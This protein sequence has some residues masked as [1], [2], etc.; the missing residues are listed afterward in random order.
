[1]SDEQPAQQFA[2]ESTY[3]PGA[4]IVVRDEEWLVKNVTRTAHDGDRIEAVGISEFVRDQEAVFFTALDDVELMDP[5]KT[6]LIDDDSP[7]FRR[8]RFFLEAVLR[9]TPLPQ[10]ERGLALADSFLLDALPYQQ[11]PAQLALSGKNL[12][13]RMLIADVVG[14]GK[15]LEIGLT[16]AELI[17]RGRGERILVVTP[18]HVLEQFQHEL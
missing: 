16:L 12:R 15:T 10:S 2:Q 11:R 7:N 4:Q 13:P 17:R 6:T 3:P 5:R 14:L 1:M 18:Q 9:K 8:S